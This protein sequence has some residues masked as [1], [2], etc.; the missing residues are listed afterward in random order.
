[1]VPVRKDPE[2]FPACHD[3]V[4]IHPKLHQKGQYTRLEV[5]HLTCNVT[6]EFLELGR[7]KLGNPVVLSSRNGCPISSVSYL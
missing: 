2:A 5:C 7:S 6:Q 1:M 4:D 3:K